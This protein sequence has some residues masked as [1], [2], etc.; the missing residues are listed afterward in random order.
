MGRLG[1]SP[2][3]LRAE[4]EEEEEAEAPLPAR[5]ASPVALSG[6]ALAVARQKREEGWTINVEDDPYALLGSRVRE[7]YGR[8]VTEAWGE[9]PKGVA[10]KLGLTAAQTEELLALNKRRWYHD[11][12]A[13]SKLG[14]GT[15]LWLPPR[16]RPAKDG[17]APE[18]GQAD[19]EGVVVAANFVGAGLALPWCVAYDDGVAADLSAVEL[20][21]GLWLQRVKEEPEWVTAPGPGL[22]APGEA[23]AEGG[24]SVGRRVRRPSKFGFARTRRR[25]HYA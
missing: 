3:K 23:A 16:R 8:Y 12:T 17:G 20:N 6:P 13:E 21:H 5:A 25:G 15:A 9:Q 14:K 11:L 4:S 2:A 1:R 19:A 22:L 24:N 10:A 18:P 7:P